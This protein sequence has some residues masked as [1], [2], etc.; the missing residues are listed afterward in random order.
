MAD[1]CTFVASPFKPSH[2]KLCFKAK[3]D[4]KI[5][6]LKPVETK[7]VVH[8]TPV[9]VST[10]SS[11]H[12]SNVVT[13][14]LQPVKAFKPLEKKQEVSPVVESKPA[15]TYK[16]QTNPQ[17]TTPIETKPIETK[18]VKT[19]KYQTNPQTTPVETKP[20]ETKPV[21]TYKY[22]TNPQPYVPDTSNKLNSSI[23]EMTEDKD[24]PTSDQND[25]P[26]L[27]VKKVFKPIGGI[28]M[29]GFDPRMLASEATKRRQKKN[30][31]DGALEEAEGKGVEKEPEPQ[32]EP[33]PLTSSGNRP[34]IGIGMLGGA[35]LAAIQKQKEKVAASE[36]IANPESAASIDVEEVVEVSIL[37]PKMKEVN[38]RIEEH[39]HELPPTEVTTYSTNV[40]TEHDS[41]E[42][43]MLNV[44]TDNT[45]KQESEEEWQ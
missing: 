31:E 44:D 7:P 27:V 45:T 34:G 26:K 17:S 13:E 22:Q 20:I 8:Q 11:P 12:N 38:Q 29:Q 19:Y 43:Q 2:C 21:K 1:N 40:P 35:G 5:P 3:V 18:P 16:Y 24:K 30:L 37:S 28:M 33:T 25:E 42:N 41:H 39:P 15:K 32:W 36:A 6:V 14:S 23:G 10:P 4:H 9:N